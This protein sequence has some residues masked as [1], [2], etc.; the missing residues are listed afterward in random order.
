MVGE[1]VLVAVE[2]EV[3]PVDSERRSFCVLGEGGA[4]RLTRVEGWKRSEAEATGSTEDLCGAVGCWKGR[5]RE[6]EASLM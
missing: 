5:G 3:G 4:E 2:V 1:A 6:A